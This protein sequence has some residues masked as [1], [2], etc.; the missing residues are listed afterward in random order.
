MS[1][2]KILSDLQQQKYQPVYLLMGDEPYFI[3]KI[4][5]YIAANVLKEEEKAFNQTIL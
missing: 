1:V 5:D 4:S 2:E 3:D